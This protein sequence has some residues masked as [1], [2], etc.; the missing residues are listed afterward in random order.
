MKPLN[1]FTVDVEDWVQ[2]T[3]DL[4]HPI[5]SRVVVNTRRMVHLLAECGV[6]ATFFVQGM[7]AEQFPEVVAEIV[8]AGHEVATHGHSH[9]P[10][11]RLGPE[12]FA[13]DLARSLEAIRAAGGGEVIGYRAPDYSIA[14]QDLPWVTE[15]L[16]RHGIRYD[17][18]VF[19]IRAPRYGIP[20][21]PRHPYP[22]GHGVVEFPLATVRL[23]GRNWPVAGGGYVRL[24]PYL[25]T[26][27]ALRRINAEGLPAMMYFHPYELDTREMRDLRPIVPWRVRLTQGLNRRW[28]AGK[29][30]ALA[31][32]FRFAP[33]REVLGL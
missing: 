3:L 14:P 9:R 17:S 7:V 16:A 25:F 11:Y 21:A 27:L 28:T 1:A 8:Q 6:R 30:R 5:T 26:R 12:G 32:D 29:I 24:F 20:D 4:S 22:L 23:L 19:P 33:A 10:V 18:S 15:V 2:S 13:A 31:R